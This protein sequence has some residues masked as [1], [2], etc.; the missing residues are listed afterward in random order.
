MGLY[1]FV[2]YKLNAVN[3]ELES[4][5]FQPSRPK[6]DILVSKFAFQI[7][8]VPLQYGLINRIKDF[9]EWSQVTILEVVALYP[10]ADKSETFDIMNALEDRLQHSNSAGVLATVGGLYNLSSS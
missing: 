5:W 4:A 7:Q 9:S 1:T 3:P 8:L 2:M 6:C 10:V